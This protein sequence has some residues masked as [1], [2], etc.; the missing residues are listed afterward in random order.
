MIF[1]ILFIVA[2]AFALTTCDDDDAPCQSPVPVEGTSSGL[3]Y[4][5]GTVKDVDPAVLATEYI[6]AYGDDIDVFSTTATYFMA[7]MNRQVLN[8]LRCDDRVSRIEHRSQTTPPKRG[9]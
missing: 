9:P 8:A 1:K 3:G 2:C 4:V 5:V 6:E 7:D